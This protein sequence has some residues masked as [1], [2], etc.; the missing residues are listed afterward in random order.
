MRKQHYMTLDERQQLEAMHRNHIS[1]A[2]IA[3]QLS[4]C[5]QTIY[6]ELRAGS[7]V[8]DCGWYDEVRYSAYKADQRHRCAQ[9]AKGRPLKIGN[10]RAYADRLEYLMLGGRDKRKRYS[11]ATALAQARRDGF[12]LTV[13]VS[14]LYS[15]ISKDIFLRLRNRDLI[16]KA[17]LL[18]SKEHT[19]QHIAH[20]NLPSIA[21]R[22]EHI[23]NRTEPGHWEMDLIVSCA[24][25]SGALLTLTERLS[26]FEI[27]RKLP[28]R[29]AET[30]QKALRSIRR[31][32]VEM[33]S[34]TTDNGPEF[35]HYADL[36][37]VT[38]CPIYYCHSYAA[39]EKGTNENHNRMIRRWFPKG[40]N[41]AEISQKEIN[42]CADWMNH[43]P[44]KVL[45]WRTPAEAFKPGYHL[46]SNSSSAEIA[47]FLA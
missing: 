10:N 24:K 42:E 33:C 13:C 32:G 35:L 19:T 7:Y 29:K 20:P 15:Y 2:E 34:I 25:G 38:G 22:P 14:T 17:K 4:F 46:S 37:A 45:G 40:T 41:F 1:V 23:N 44:R 11:P 3:R 39:W 6:N 28:D 47:A 36:Q 30:V 43:Y 31:Q 5:R 18:K 21:D 9:T 8:H 27:I 12:T 26:R 16:E